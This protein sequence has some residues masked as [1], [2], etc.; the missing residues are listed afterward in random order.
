MI[1]LEILLYA[2]VYD[3]SVSQ[4]EKH[5]CVSSRNYKEHRGVRL[6]NLSPGNYSVRVRAT[7][8]AWNGSWT[9]PIP[10]YISQ[11]ERE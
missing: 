7:S 1:S 2:D 11:P 8:L 3:C 5:E 4:L 6:T 9:K 10:M